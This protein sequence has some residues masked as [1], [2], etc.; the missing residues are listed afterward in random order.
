MVMLEVNLAW[1]PA[2]ISAALA[3]RPVRSLISF[4]TM[5]STA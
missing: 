1:C 2:A 3:S 5:R 4:W